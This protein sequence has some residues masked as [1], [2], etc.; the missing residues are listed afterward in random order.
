MG[1]SCDQVSFREA[2]ESFKVSVCVLAVVGLCQ[3]APQVNTNQVVQ[4]V[5][6]QLQPLISDAVARALASISISSSSSSSGFARGSSSGSFGAT[7]GAAVARGLSEEEELEYNRKLNANAAYEYG[8][9]VAND[10]KQTYMAHEETRK[11]PDVQGKYN[12]V[13]ANGDLVTVTYTAGVDGYNEERSV[14]PGAVT[15]RAENIAGPWEGPLAGQTEVE[16]VPAPRAPAPRPAPRPAAP[17]PAPAELSPLQFKLSG[18]SPLPLP[19]SFLLATTPSGSQLQSSTL[20]TKPDRNKLPEQ[21]DD[22]QT[23]RHVAQFGH[24]VPNPKS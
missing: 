15:Y 7:S 24:F 13:D 11:G 22:T 21:Q 1:V 5:T 20:N 10:E 12:Y 9:K 17:A 8:Y 19:H 6:T 2:M 23:N 3:S 16:V 14:T 4:T 18:L